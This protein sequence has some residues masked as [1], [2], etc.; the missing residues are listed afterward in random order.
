MNLKRTYFWVFLVA[1]GVSPFVPHDACAVL[2]CV[3]HTS[4][5]A[6][7]LPLLTL[8]SFNVLGP[9]ACPATFAFDVSTG[10]VGRRDG[11]HSG[12]RGNKTRNW[13]CF[14]PT[15]TDS[16]REKLDGDADDDVER[17]R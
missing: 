9:S 6:N 14:S 16:D 11:S 5:L 13:L 8:S 12:R 2:S 1:Q 3:L 10:V 4:K 7:P 15:T 17:D